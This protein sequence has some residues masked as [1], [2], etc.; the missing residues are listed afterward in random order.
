MQDSNTKTFIV[1]E[2][3]RFPVHMDFNVNTDRQCLLPRPLLSPHQPWLFTVDV[4]PQTPSNLHQTWLGKC[5]T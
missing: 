2:E 5:Y 1:S 4:L 3:G